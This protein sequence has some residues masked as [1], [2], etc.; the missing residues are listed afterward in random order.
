MALSAACD[1]YSS[2]F[3]LISVSTAS[4]TIKCQNKNR[5]LLSTITMINQ[6]HFNCKKTI[7]LTKR[8]REHQLRWSHNRLIKRQNDRLL[9]I[10]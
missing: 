5:L 2:T 9:F 3:E 7:L 4:L 10:S 1:T 8:D 6:S